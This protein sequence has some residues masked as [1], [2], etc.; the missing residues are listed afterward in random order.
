MFN[1][2]M[3]FLPFVHISR[4]EQNFTFCLMIYHTVDGKSK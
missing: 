3:L 1:I 2:A 4:T